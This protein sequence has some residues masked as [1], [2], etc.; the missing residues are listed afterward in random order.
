MKPAWSS[1]WKSSKKP[2]KQRKYRLNAPLHI[3]HK[4]LSAGLSKDLRKKYGKRSLPVRKGDKVKIMIG[5]FK[6]HV[7]KVSRINLKKSKVYIEGAEMVKKDGGKVLYPIYA[8]NTE[9]LDLNLDD[10][11]RRKMLERK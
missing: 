1:K 8:S 3:K 6:K 10:K 4:F 2:N 7:G 5:Q 9:I 11:E